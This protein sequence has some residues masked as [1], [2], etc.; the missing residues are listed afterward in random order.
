MAK[1]MIRHCENCGRDLGGEVE[2][3]YGDDMV[4]CGER[5]CQREAN[6]DAQA[7]QD[8]RRHAAEDDHYER[9]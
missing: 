1:R 7:R 5:E 2:K 8:D 9:Y 4:T 6:Y 3:W